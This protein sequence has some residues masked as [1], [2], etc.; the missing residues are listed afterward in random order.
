MR[1]VC[2]VQR[3][4]IITALLALPSAASASSF[5][6]NF[7]IDVTSVTG[8][9]ATAFSGLAAGDVITGQYTFNDATPDTNASPLFGRFDFVTPGSAA[10][11]ITVKGK[12]IGW[13]GSRI[14]TFNGGVD[15]YRILNFGTFLDD[16]VF[17]AASFFGQ[18]NGLASL[19]ASTAQPTTPP[20]VSAFTSNLFSMFVETQEG[21]GNIDGTFRSLSTQPV[22][23][24]PE[25]ASMLLVGSG[26]TALVVRRRR[27]R[28]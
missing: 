14:E 17:G 19:L 15:F 22:T 13:T 11:S 8:V 27:S 20:D 16:P 23:A 6:F 25:P 2:L 3:I 4:V 26:L 28:R 1:I 21:D 24:V 9:A 18:M 5:T 7:A 10:T 12:T